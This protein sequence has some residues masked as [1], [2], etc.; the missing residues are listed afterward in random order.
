MS[1]FGIENVFDQIAEISAK[2]AE[3]ADN[4]TIGQAKELRDCLTGCG[5]DIDCCI[6]C[7]YNLIIIAIWENTNQY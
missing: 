3:I 7:M 6:D 1:D 2:V 4:L 5:Y